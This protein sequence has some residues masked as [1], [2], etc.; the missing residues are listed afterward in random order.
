MV[1][2]RNLHVPQIQVAADDLLHLL[3]NDLLTGSSGEVLQRGLVT[4]LGGL[5]QVPLVDE[6]LLQL[7]TTALGSVL[8]H[9]LGQ[10]GRGIT[11]QSSPNVDLA[12][13]VVK[14]LLDLKDRSQHRR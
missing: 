8:D 9:E 4:S 12:D 11:L 14:Q 13:T 6:L 2:F 1:D 10:C 3:E 5:G 7:G